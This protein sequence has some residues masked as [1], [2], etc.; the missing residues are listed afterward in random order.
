M[1]RKRRSLSSCLG[2]VEPGEPGRDEVCIAAD[3][4]GDFVW[5]GVVPVQEDDG[6]STLAASVNVLVGAV[7]VSSMP[8]GIGNLK[9]GCVDFSRN[10]L[11]SCLAR[12]CH[13]MDKLSPPREYDRSISAACT[14]AGAR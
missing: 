9:T 12:S 10:V 11:Y 1:L 6:G 7:D 3:T 2:S 8:V 14:D 5:F 4:G 13:C